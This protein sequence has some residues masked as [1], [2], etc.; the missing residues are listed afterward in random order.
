MIITTNKRTN[1]LSEEPTNKQIIMEPSEEWHQLI[2]EYD[3]ARMMTLGHD[4]AQ[5]KY[6]KERTKEKYDKLLEFVVK[7]PEYQSKLPVYFWG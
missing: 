4:E 2:Y 6:V 3:A 7:H 5:N 1:C